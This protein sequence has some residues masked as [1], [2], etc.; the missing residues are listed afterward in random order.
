MAE[1]TPTIESVLRKMT[2]LL[3]RHRAGDDDDPDADPT[4]DRASLKARLAVVA[5]ERKELRAAVEAL[6]AETTDVTAKM[7]AEFDAKLAEER[8]T[9]ARQ[10]GELARLR[11]EDLALAD[12]GFKAPGEREAVRREFLA[13]PEATRP[14]E[15]AAAWWSGIVE[16]R[17]ADPA[18]V[19]IPRTLAFALPPD[20][21]PAE[22]PAP[23]RPGMPRIEVGVQRGKPAAGAERIRAAATFEDLLKETL[24]LDNQR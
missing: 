24:A 10:A 20:E 12:L 2:D 9:L 14:K 18:K 22:E 8:K 16:A 7:R 17:K 6:R 19:T 15:G 21:K 4:G 5:R 13:L 3:T 23:A 1:E 11:D